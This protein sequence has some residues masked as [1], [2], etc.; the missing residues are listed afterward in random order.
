M[1]PTTIPEY[2]AARLRRVLVAGLAALAAGGARPAWSM[3]KPA[4]S[5][6]AGPEPAS[7]LAVKLA[8]LEKLVEAAEDRVSAGQVQV[9][10]ARRQLAQAGN[11]AEEAEAR[12]AL[13]RCAKAL[14]SS[15]KLYREASARRDA[16]ALQASPGSKAEGKGDAK[17]TGVEGKA[18]TAPATPRPA[19]HPFFGPSPKHGPGDVLRF[20]IQFGRRSRALGRVVRTADGN[21]YWVDPETGG[22][23][24][25]GPGLA[26]GLSWLN[27]PGESTPPMDLLDLQACGDT[28]W[29]FSGRPGSGYRMHRMAGNGQ[30]TGFTVTV[31]LDQAPFGFLPWKSASRNPPPSRRRTRS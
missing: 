2:V 16:L 22:L 18:G 23:G 31:K 30:G 9:A 15:A 17:T 20:N 12:A 25:L 28:L 14:Q 8:K 13:E 29:C 6:G 11:L 21:L 1:V 4:P 5:A 10:K 26:P 27:S 7:D 19:R 24:G 3:D